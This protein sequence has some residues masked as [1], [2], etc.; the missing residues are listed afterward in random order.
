M[1]V[2]GVDLGGT[3]LSAAA[4]SEDGRLVQRQIEHL[5]GR[6]GAEVSD[7]IIQL[8]GQVKDEQARSGHSV[9]AV[10]VSVPG[11]Y[12]AS[13]GRVWAP[14]IP[15]WD[16]FPL[17]SNLTS[18]LDSTLNV[19]ID[20]DRACY[21]LGETWQG[22]ARGCR[23]A[24]FLAVGTGIGAGILTGGEVLR[25]HHDIAGAIGWLALDRNYRAEYKTYGCF[26]YHASGDGLARVGRD[27]LTRRSDYYDSWSHA[28]TEALTARD[29]FDAYERGDRLAIDV[30]EEAISFWGM[31]VANLVSLFN[32][33]MIILGGGVFGPATRFVDRIREEASRWAQPISMKEV[34]IGVTRLG[35]DAGL[36]GAAFL[37]LRALHL[38]NRSSYAGH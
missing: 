3:K 30:L 14:N 16:D 27:L 38:A 6:Q 2:I 33:E 18:S 19:H 31:A 34:K 12:Y 29:L 32:P 26:E 10:G 15:G 22:E 4:F 17:L 13:T 7:L 21:I 24:I 8:V 36:Y 1:G 35:G 5:D 11:I 23:D 9:N 20:S 37:S 25:G 28:N